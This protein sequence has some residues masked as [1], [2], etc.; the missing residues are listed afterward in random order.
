VTVLAYGRTDLFTDGQE[1]FAQD[2]AGTIRRPEV[3][4][5][6]EAAATL[7][8]KW[9][10]KRIL[11]DR[12]IIDSAGAFAPHTG[13]LRIGPV[14][15]HELPADAVVIGVPRRPCD[16]LYDQLEGASPELYLVGDA[17]TPRTVEEAVAEGSAA[18]R[19]IGGA[20]IEP[21]MAAAVGS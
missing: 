7:R 14:D 15:E 20:R 19:S 2:M 21:S 18:A 13:A 9:G 16:E 10:I 8:P 12:V 17:S 3:L 4:K 5:Q 1:E 6:L 11:D